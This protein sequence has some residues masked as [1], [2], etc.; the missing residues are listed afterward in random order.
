MCAVGVF[1][2]GAICAKDTAIDDVLVSCLGYFWLS[3]EGD[4]LGCS[5]EASNLLAKTITP[6][7]LV[8]GVLQ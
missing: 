8:L 1:P 6:H 5:G 3:H 4:G 2:L 7:I